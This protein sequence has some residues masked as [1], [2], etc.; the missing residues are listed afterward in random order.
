MADIFI[1]Y[2][3]EDRKIASKLASALE[4]QGWSVWWDRKIIAGASFD[5]VIEYELET[6]KSIIVLWSES[7]ISS[8]WVKNEA[9][10]AVERGVL[11]PAMIDNVKL[12]L[13]FRRKQTAD[14]V[15]W[16]GN[17][18]NR[19]FKVLCGGVSATA[20][21]SNVVPRHPHKS[22]WD[23]FRWNR[24]W[25]L[26]AT[27]TIIVALGFAIYW[28]QLVKQQSE[29]QISAKAIEG[30]WYA[31]IQYS[32]GISQIEEFDFIVDGEQL[33]GTASFD[34]GPRQIIDGR[35]S[36]NQLYFRT[37]LDDRIFQYR[38]ETVESQ[39]QFTLDN[40]FEPP[41]KFVAARTVEEA[42]RLRP[43]RPSGGTEPRLTSI[44][45]GPY[46]LDHIK[47]KVNQLH[48]DIRQCY[49]ATEFDPVDHDNVLYFLKIGRNGTVSET[50]APGTDQRS[51]ELDGCM[52]RAFRNVNWGA[53]PNG[54]DAEIR[55]GF[56]A[57]P[58]WRIQ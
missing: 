34:K 4:A 45:T 11:V 27:I 48:I 33:I 42:R 21:I 12:P 15:G 10:V 16:D 26:I 32:W 22:L 28:G 13:E 17:L 7:S 31:D 8:E 39:I 20:N 41:T 29:S 5:Q 25:I 47:T 1:S 53:T 2:A 35:L 51:V 55:L 54:M 9:A 36:K 58:A 56:K 14:I 50:G 49:I 24:R 43:R 30:I 52:D 18:S 6:A 37:N 57:L 38:G 44:H 46:K 19:G 3:N 23:R 40:K